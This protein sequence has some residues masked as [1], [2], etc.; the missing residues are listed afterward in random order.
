MG[1]QVC[2]CRGHKD[3]GGDDDCDKVDLPDFADESSEVWRFIFLQHTLIA[4]LQGSPAASS[5]AR[6]QLLPPLVW[7]RRA[8]AL[9]EAVD[10]ARPVLSHSVC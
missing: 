6:S 9:L 2:A 1:N 5:I 10:E 7:W 8:F 4:L 3:H